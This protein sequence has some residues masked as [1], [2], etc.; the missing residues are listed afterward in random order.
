MHL[1]ASLARVRVGVGVRGRG[2]GRG[3]GRFR[4]GGT[5]EQDETL[6]QEVG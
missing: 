4:L 1:A 5:A 6:P 2:R 3:R